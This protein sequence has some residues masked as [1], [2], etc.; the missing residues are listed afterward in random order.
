VGCRARLSSRHRSNSTCSIRRC[1]HAAISRASARAA[2]RYQGRRFW[3]ARQ[4]ASVSR[5]SATDVREGAS[6][7]GQTR[8]WGVAAPWVRTW[9]DRLDGF[10]TR[11]VDGGDIAG[12]RCRQ[13]IGHR[14][15][16]SAQSR[17]HPS[18][19]AAIRFP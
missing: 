16:P 1:H 19:F 17:E 8:A 9:L 6:V 11:A 14:S 2:R 13:L 15:L 18:Q 4:E 3:H 12:Q 7:S 5:A 10:R